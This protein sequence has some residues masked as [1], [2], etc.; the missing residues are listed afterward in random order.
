[1]GEE[2]SLEAPSSWSLGTGGSVQINCGVSP[3]QHELPLGDS[4]KGQAPPAREINQH[5]QISDL[6]EIWANDVHVIGIR[7]VLSV[8]DATMRR[9]AR[10]RRGVCGVAPPFRTGQ[11]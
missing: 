2:P 4:S 9:C 11:K 10:S 5:S 8:A 1:M 7:M 3:E 6:Q